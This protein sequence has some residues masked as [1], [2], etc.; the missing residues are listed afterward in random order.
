[1]A[2]AAQGT[3]LRERRDLL[4]TAARWEAAGDWER[5]HETVLNWLGDEAA[6]GLEPGQPE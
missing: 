6:V 2:F 5:R 1:M 4:E 3:R